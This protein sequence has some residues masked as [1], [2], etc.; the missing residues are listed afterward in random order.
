MGF[1]DGRM[2]LIDHYQALPAGD[3]YFSLSLIG[4]RGAVYADDHQNM[5]LLYRGD[6][7]SAL[8]TGPGNHHVLAQLQE[9]VDAIGQN[10]APLITANDGRRATRIADATR[11]SITSGRPVHLSE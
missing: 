1:A 11:Q 3:N 7:P 8:R 10:R 5:Q 9:F 6:S 4:S 2:A